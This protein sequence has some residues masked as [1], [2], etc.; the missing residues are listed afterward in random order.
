MGCMRVLRK[1]RTS[2]PV[3]ANNANE[4]PICSQMAARRASELLLAVRVAAPACSVGNSSARATWFSGTSASSSMVTSASKDA[5]RK[6]R[7]SNWK[8][9]PADPTWESMAGSETNN[10]GS[11]AAKPAARPSPATRPSTPS[12]RF[13][14]SN[15]RATVQRR[16]PKAR[17]KATSGPRAKATRQQQM[18]HVHDSQQKYAANN[19]KQNQTAS[20]RIAH[21]IAEVR[22]NAR[23]TSTIGSRVGRSPSLSSCGRLFV[24]LRHCGPPAPDGPTD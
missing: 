12:K 5:K 22:N 9:V 24:G 11:K 17:R 8:P 15:C 6:T 23:S 20:A 10:R 14:T 21:A 13:S 19:G 16:A 7:P 3:E 4:T 18:H 1:L 2:T